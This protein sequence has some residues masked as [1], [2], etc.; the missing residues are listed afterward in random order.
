M[1]VLL[2]HGGLG[3][4]VEGSFACDQSKCM[5]P[6]SS[7]LYYTTGKEKYTLIVYVALYMMHITFLVSTRLGTLA[8]EAGKKRSKT[9]THRKSLVGRECMGLALYK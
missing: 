4:E 1:Y 7:L 3:S 2:V 8:K 6:R 5:L 9:A